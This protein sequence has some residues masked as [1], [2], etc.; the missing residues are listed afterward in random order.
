MNNQI[1]YEQ[2]NVSPLFRLQDK[3]KSRRR[4]R[5]I[6]TTGSMINSTRN[7]ELAG[8]DPVTENKKHQQV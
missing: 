2:K 5:R 3:N 1:K 4:T 6:L 8:L 7:K